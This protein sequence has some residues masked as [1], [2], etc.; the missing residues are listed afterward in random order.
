M[1]SP[2]DPQPEFELRLEKLRLEIEEMKH[3]GAWNRRLG[4]YLPVLSTVIPLVALTLT[5]WQLRYQSQAAALTAQ[6][7]FMEPVLTRQF[8]SYF[9]ASAAAATLAGSQNEEERQKAREA[10]FRLYWSP[11]VI[12]ESGPVQEREG[13]WVVLGSKLRRRRSARRSLLLFQRSRICLI[14][15]NSHRRLMR[16]ERST[17]RSIARRGILTQSRALLLNRSPARHR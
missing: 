7:A 8:N 16:I 17:T 15:G 6:R 11:L 10:F 5:V 2:N 1:E 9:E 12:L 4:R 3:N 13:F 14:P